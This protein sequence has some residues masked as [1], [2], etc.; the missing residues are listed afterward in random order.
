MAVFESV[1]DANSA[2]LMNTV[3]VATKAGF[4]DQLVDEGHV[5]CAKPDSLELIDV[6]PDGSWEYQNIDDDGKA[7]TM[8]NTSAVMLTLYLSPQHRAAFAE[9]SAP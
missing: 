6:F 2:A 5:L 4:T 7:E 3:S 9:G 1:D 8:S